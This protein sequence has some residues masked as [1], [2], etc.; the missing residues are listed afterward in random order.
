M[1]NVSHFTD[2]YFSRSKEILRLDNLNPMVRA[3]VFIRKGGRPVYGVE[4]ALD[5]MSVN[6]VLDNALVYYL[7]DGTMYEDGDTV[8]VMYVPIRDIVEWETVYLG[9]ISNKTSCN[10]HIDIAM[11]QLKRAEENTYHTF[12][13]ISELIGGRGMLYFGARHNIWN[14]DESISTAATAGGAIACS[15]D[16]GAKASFGVDAEGIGTIPHALENIYAWKF[17][18]RSFGVVEATKAFDKYIDKKIPR[19][20][21]IDYNNR[22]YADFCKV[23]KEVPSL[24]GIRIDT[25]GEN[26]MELPKGDFNIDS[27]DISFGNHAH[28]YHEN[29]NVTLPFEDLQHWFGTGVKVWPVYC[30]T[31]NPP[32]I[33]IEERRVIKCCLTSGFGKIDKVKAFI[34]AEEELETQLFDTLGMGDVFGVDGWVNA[35]MDI[36]HVGNSIDDLEEYGKIG[37]RKKVNE[38]LKLFKK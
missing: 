37:R 27:L 26:E 3:Q 4:E 16:N 11:E 21:L 5:L 15:T 29:R 35:T 7:P 6:G 33:P 23:I 2:K 14:F 24:E 31:K 36:T 10:N 30:M 1:F 34:R 28:F 9:I 8:M 18:E 32:S 17:G 13:A 38:K 22:E 12:R 25:C 20:A 19:I